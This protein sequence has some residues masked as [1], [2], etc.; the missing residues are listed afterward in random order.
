MVRAKEE[1]WQKFRRDEGHGHCVICSARCICEWWHP[2]SVFGIQFLRKQ[3]CYNIPRTFVVDNIVVLGSFWERFFK[4]KIKKIIMPQDQCSFQRRRI[5]ERQVRILGLG[6]S[7]KQR[8]Y[9]SCTS[10]CRKNDFGVLEL[11]MLV[12]V[13]LYW[14][15]TTYV[16]Q[17]RFM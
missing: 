5:A 16:V 8:R 9:C 11:L 4:K 7:G 10:F 2:W 17:A 1:P 6:C 14:D 3:W 13:F 15:V 12:M